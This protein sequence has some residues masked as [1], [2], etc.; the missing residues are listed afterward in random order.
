M[1]LFVFQQRHRARKKL[2]I[3]SEVLKIE[4]AEENLEMVGIGTSRAM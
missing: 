3:I 4:V 2:K 1:T